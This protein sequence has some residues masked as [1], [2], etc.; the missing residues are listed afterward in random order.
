MQFK[1]MVSALLLAGF[2]AGCAQK[3]ESSDQKG[4]TLAYEKASDSVLVSVT[5][6]V[7]ASKDMLVR[8]LVVTD[9]PAGFEDLRNFNLFGPRPNNDPTTG[10]ALGEAGGKTS[11]VSND[12]TDMTPGN[13]PITGQGF[14]LLRKGSVGYTHRIALNSLP[15]SIQ[16]KLRQDVQSLALCKNL[17]ECGDDVLT[18]LTIGE[19]YTG[20]AL[21]AP[22]K[23][24]ID[25]TEGAKPGSIEIKSKGELDL[26]KP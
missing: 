7:A 4:G 26:I 20:T 15:Q 10:L 2:S 13:D 1:L 24:M 9:V 21:A 19:E 3:D 5:L 17:P 6:D 14:M 16:S 11:V 18:L 25:L 22:R 12:P 8:G 23:V